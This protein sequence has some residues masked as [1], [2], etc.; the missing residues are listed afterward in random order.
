[1]CGLRASGSSWTAW[2]E[3]ELLCSHSLPGDGAIS[4]CV[5]LALYIMEAA[6]VQHSALGL[7]ARCTLLL[8]R[9]V[10]GRCMLPCHCCV[11]MYDHL[12]SKL[13]YGEA[14]VQDVPA[15]HACC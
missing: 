7:V 5:P 1:M 11:M 2:E 4:V 10:Q 8:A 15:Q 3:G 9:K 6:S 12:L 13:L 14:S